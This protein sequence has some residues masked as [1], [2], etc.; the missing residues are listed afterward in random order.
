M[1]IFYVYALIDPRNK[2]PFYI[3]K[4]KNGRVFDH[5]LHIDGNRHKC[6]KISKLY[7]LGL[8]PEIDII[9]MNL[10]DREAL[11]LEIKTIKK[12]GRIDIK[13]GCLTNLT[14]GGE[15]VSGKHFTAAYR[16]R[17]SK[18]NQGTAN[19]NY[20]NKWTNSQKQHMRLLQKI[21]PSFRGKHHS[22][23]SK[24]KIS[25]YQ[26][27]HSFWQLS[28]DGRNLTFWRSIRDFCIA[29]G[30]FIPPNRNNSSR[31]YQSLSN[32]RCKF[33]N[34]YLR[35]LTYDNIKD[36]KLLDLNRFLAESKSIRTI[37]RTVQ[38]TITG[39]VI[40]IWESRS[41]IIAANSNMR[42]TTLSTAITHKRAYAGY[43]WENIDA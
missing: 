25:A 8:S 28:S 23:K 16:A 21:K 2:V 17:L 38:K 6:N 33:K 14:D 19:P 29:N 40:R 36:G 34:T 37:K 31:V 3:G 39:T 24:R 1:N 10:S 27:R 5:F 41:A 9:G 18:Q 4:G 35:E 11:D 20:G 7:S 30:L 15:G 32:P 43:V 42:L 12:Y 26:T 13:T 22:N